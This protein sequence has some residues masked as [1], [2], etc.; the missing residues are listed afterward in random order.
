MVKLLNVY[1]NVDI[2]IV[3]TLRKKV[4]ITRG[5]ELTLVE[6][7]LR[8]DIRKYSFSQRKINEWDKSPTHCVNTSSV[9]MFKNKVAKHIRKVGYT[10]MNNCWI[11]Q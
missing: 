5:H 10:N 2:G 9:N 4:G 1:A 6:E 7:L 8:L 3:Y 11:N